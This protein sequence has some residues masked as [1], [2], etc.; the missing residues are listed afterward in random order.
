MSVESLETKEIIELQLPDIK[1]SLLQHDVKIT[2]LSVSL[3][4]GSL[5]SNPRNSGFS[6]E[7]GDFF[8]NTGL[9]R[10]ETYEQGDEH[11]SNALTGQEITSDGQVNLLI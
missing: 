7:R 11:R 3:N 9:D 6:N 4:N 2:E 5:G 8:D 1:Q 10:G